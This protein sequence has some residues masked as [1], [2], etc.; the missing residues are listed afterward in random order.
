MEKQAFIQPVFPFEKFKE[1]LIIA[2]LLHFHQNHHFHRI[3]LFL[4]RKSF[5]ILLA[6]PGSIGMPM[7]WAQTVSAT[8]S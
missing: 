4:L 5:L 3:H 8:V 2:L 6:Q 7:R 1:L